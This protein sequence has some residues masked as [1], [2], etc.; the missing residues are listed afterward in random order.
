MKPDELNQCRA[1]GST[2]IVSDGQHKVRRDGDSAPLTPIRRLRANLALGH[3][4]PAREDLA[5][6]ESRVSGRGLFR[7]DVVDTPRRAR[8]VNLSVLPQITVG[9]SHVA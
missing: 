7:H 8:F 9:T 1:A 2:N 5:T 3:P 6:V 4:G